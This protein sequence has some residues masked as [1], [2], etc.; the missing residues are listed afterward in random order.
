MIH[1]HLC[2]LSFIPLPPPHR[3]REE[4]MQILFKLKYGDNAK[5]LC[6]SRRDSS[7]DRQIKS[8]L[9]KKPRG[10]KKSKKVRIASLEEGT[11]SRIGENDSGI[12]MVEVD[13]NN[14]TAAES[15]S[16]S[17]GTKQKDG[18]DNKLDRE[19]GEENLE[20]NDEGEKDTEGLLSSAHGTSVSGSGGSEH[21]SLT[22]A[23]LFRDT[24]RFLLLGFPG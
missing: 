2:L 4:V 7:S 9:S 20:I 16:S 8:S 10:K 14:A 17:N 21:T 12:E 6:L 5:D 23:S 11:S 13:I 1:L 19:D 22:N 24:L 3:I 18:R 15:N